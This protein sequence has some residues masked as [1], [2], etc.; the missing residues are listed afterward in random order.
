MFSLGS[1]LQG[2]VYHLIEITFRSLILSVYI[3]YGLA[4]LA[5]AASLFYMQS[6]GE[7]NQIN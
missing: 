4:V 7:N 6:A 3:Y 5:T 2:I 1:V